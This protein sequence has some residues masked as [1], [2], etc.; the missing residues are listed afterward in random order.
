MNNVDELDFIALG[1]LNI[2]PMHGYELH[3]KIADLSGL[4]NVW[5]LKISKLYAIL[6]RLKKRDYIIAET[7]AA[8]NRPPKKVFHITP[9]GKR[10]FNNWVSN[11]VEHGRDFR[12]LFLAKLFFL[13]KINNDLYK[14]L[15][16]RQIGKCIEWKNTFQ[17]QIENSEG[18]NYFEKI[19]LKFRYSQIENYI[20]WLQWCLDQ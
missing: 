10:E 13:K 3:G 14:N 5:N 17:D 8:E 15:I 20:N 7:E 18:L 19:V 1:F 16:N 11:P 12:Q 9:R 2:C 6:N 4:G